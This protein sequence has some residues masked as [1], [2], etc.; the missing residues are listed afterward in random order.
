LLLK[1]LFIVGRNIAYTLSPAIY[2]QLFRER[3]VDARYTVVDTDEQ[4]AKEAMNGCR[5]DD[6]CLGFNVTK[7][8]KLLAAREVDDL[9]AHAAAIG[10]VN[11]VLR[12]GGRLVGYNTDW[13]GVL[14]PLKRFDPPATYDRVLIIGAGGAAR[15]A[16]YA[17]SDRASRLYIVS[18]TGVSAANLARWAS[19]VL[20]AEARGHRSTSSVYREILPTVDLVVNAS[21]AS[22]KGSSPI[23]PSLLRGLRSEATVFDMVYTPPRTL[24]LIEASKRGCKT[25]DGLWMLA[26]QAARNLEL[27]LGLEASPDLLRAYAINEVLRR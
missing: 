10:A 1:R 26:Y 12:R 15:A 4:G 19:T 11:T 14:E 25:V 13:L 20:G 21:P 24:L 9:D 7:P 17:L 2:N 3:G 6:S 23:P 18:A 8:Y 5:N 22:S 27:W 16:V